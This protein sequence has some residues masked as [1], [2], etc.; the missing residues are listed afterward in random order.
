[1]KQNLPERFRDKQSSGFKTTK[2]DGANGTFLIPHCYEKDW[3]YL[4]VISDGMGWEH[5]SVSIYNK[6]KECG[7]ALTPSWDDMCVV[8]DLF[9]DADEMVIQ[10]HP[11]RSMYVNNH[12]HC[13]HLWRCTLAPPY[14]GMPMPNP[15]MVGLIDGF[16]LGE[17]G[18][19]TL[20]RVQKI[21]DGRDNGMS[22]YTTNKQQ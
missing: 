7:M 5:V 6:R 11:P 17:E 21:L 12:K 16:V 13:L 14:D 15:M 2:E 10:I 19:K 3:M 8:K 18:K 4:V 22:N 1:M 20:D 9:F